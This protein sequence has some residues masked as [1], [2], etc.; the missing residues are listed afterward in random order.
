MRWWA[1]NQALADARVERGSYKCAGCSE[2]FKRDQIHI[3]HIEP[4]IPVD[5]TFEDW[6]TFIERL[7]C[8]PEGLQVLCVQC[9]EDKTLCEN[10]ARDANKTLKRLDKKKKV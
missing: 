8:G 9:H 5:G 3:D 7:F 6:N 10:I 4:V 2:L 1:M